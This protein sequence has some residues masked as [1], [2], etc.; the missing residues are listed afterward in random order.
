MVLTRVSNV[1]QTWRGTRDSGAVPLRSVL[2][3]PNWRR[4][5]GPTEIGF[6]R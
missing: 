5:R 6:W 4:G 2:A 1:R 3:L